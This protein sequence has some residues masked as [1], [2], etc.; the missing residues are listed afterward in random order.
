M[1]VI[2]VGLVHMW[3]AAMQQTHL[4]PTIFVHLDRLCTEP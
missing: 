3:E 4:I 1:N 2:R